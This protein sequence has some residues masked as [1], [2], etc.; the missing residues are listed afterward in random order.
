VLKSA[1]RYWPRSNGLAGAAAAKKDERVREFGN[2]WRSLA[3]PSHNRLRGANPY[4]RVDKRPSA[5]RKTSISQL[6]IGACRCNFGVGERTIKFNRVVSRMQWPQPKMQV[7][8][9]RRLQGH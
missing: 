8:S 9:S 5:H 2:E 6:Q 3:G 4:R 1:P 7:V